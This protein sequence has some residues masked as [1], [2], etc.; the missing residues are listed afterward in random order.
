MRVLLD[1]CVISELRK[2]KRAHKSV[3][4]WQTKVPLA[5]Q[6]VS[7]VSLFELSL[8][9]E[10]KYRRDKEAGEHLRNWYQNKVRPA[11]QGRI[12]PVDEFVAEKAAVFNVPVTRAFRDSLIAATAAVHDMVVVSRNEKDFRDF[13]VKVVN[14]WSYRE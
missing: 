6:Y 9:I 14:P 10:L 12:L 1:T 4:A 13:A 3:Q 8:G 5:F 7:A 11:F 2:G